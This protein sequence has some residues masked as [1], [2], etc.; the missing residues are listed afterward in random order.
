MHFGS[1][2]TGAFFIDLV[3]RA[4]VLMIEGRGRLRLLQEPLLGGVVAGQVRGEELDGDLALQARVLG[5]V[6]DPH[7]AVTEFGED[8]IRAESGAWGEGHGGAG[9]CR[10]TG[11]G[12][13]G[14]RPP[15]VLSSVR[16]QRRARHASLADLCPNLIRRTGWSRGDAIHP[17]ANLCEKFHTRR[18]LECC[19]DQEV[20][21]E[22]R[23]PRVS[24][25]LDKV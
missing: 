14:V 1:P 19:S 11:C 22:S 20:S 6:D 9:L 12:M 17:C 7:A 8:R 24:T 5:R 21:V 18:P 4:D 23:C 25:A 15:R 16:P 13:A 10:G 3:D 2:R